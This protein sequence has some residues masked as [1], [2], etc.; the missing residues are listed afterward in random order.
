MQAILVL[1]LVNSMFPDA[2]PAVFFCGDFNAR[3][4]PAESGLYLLLHNGVAPK[5]NKE[6]TMEGERKDLADQ[7]PEPA[8]ALCKRTPLVS[9][10]GLLGHEQ[11]FTHSARG[12]SSTIDYI[13][14]MPAKVK[15]QEILQVFDKSEMPHG[16]PTLHYG[17]DHIC[18]CARFKFV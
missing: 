13:Y 18:L 10:Y 7:S 5:D 12:W 3:C 14:S 11:P 8:V 1:D 4:P 9:T 2:L 6:W 15:A 17:G 16:L